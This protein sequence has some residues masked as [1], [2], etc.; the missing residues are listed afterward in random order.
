M[1]ATLIKQKYGKDLV[2]LVKV[3]PLPPHPQ[4][5]KLK[6]HIVQE[7]TCRVLLGGK[8]FDS[9]YTLADNSKVV[10]TDTVK[11]TIY[12]L[13]KKSPASL[14]TIETFA[15]DIAVHFL[16]K[17]AHVQTVDV[18]IAAH[19]WT[20][21]ATT[22]LQP[23]LGSAPLVAHPHSFF[24]A[25]EDKRHVQLVATRL[26]TPGEGPLKVQF[27]TTSGLTDLYVLKTTGSS[28]ERFHR[29]ELTTLPD[30]ADRIFSTTVE[31]YWTFPTRV[32]T[33]PVV[34]G[35]A[36][37]AIPY[38]EI[39]TGIRQ[40]TVD[41][42]ANHD[43]PSVQNTLWRMGTEIL[44]LYPDVVDISYALPNKHVFAY[45]TDRFGLKNLRE[46]TNVYYPVADPSGLITATI[47]R[48]K[49]KL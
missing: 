19:N 42:F 39:Y 25:G 22:T 41:L 23:P 13:A 18:K 33:F 15:H 2:R 14:L 26:S 7:L 8:E 17:Y 36:A 37:S 45:D 10:P 43:S 9:S 34:I 44:K 47:G 46:G 21:I 27:A 1:S 32:E 12:Y 3:S 6:R 24:R 48:S 4:A 29:D 35:A 30:M 40:V 11:N 49:P 5:P 28:F 20:R 16:E 38:D 31:A